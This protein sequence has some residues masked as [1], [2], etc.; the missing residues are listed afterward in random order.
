MI[1]LPWKFI[2]LLKEIFPTYSVLG[3]LN[4]IICKVLVQR[5]V[6]TK[7][8]IN[9]AY[10]APFLP[11]STLAFPNVQYNFGDAFSL[12][13][14]WKIL[15]MPKSLTIT[16]ILSDS[17]PYPGFVSHFYLPTINFHI[18]GLLTHGIQNF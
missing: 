5:L 4:V 6:H 13:S 10:C 17:V 1:F 14:A 7:Y 9:C 11:L 3:T 18:G 12:C 16:S 15:S 8:S 2:P